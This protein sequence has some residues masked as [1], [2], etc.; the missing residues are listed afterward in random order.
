MSGIENISQNNLIDS[1]VRRRQT[2]FYRIGNKVRKFSRWAMGRVAYN[3]GTAIGIAD[4]IITVTQ[5]LFKVKGVG[6]AARPLHEVTQVLSAIFAPIWFITASWD[7]YEEFSSKRAPAASL[8]ELGQRVFSAASTVFWWGESILSL[9]LM[10]CSF[11]SKATAAIPILGL[12]DSLVSAPAALFEAISQ[13]FEIK[14]LEEKKKLD[15]QRLEH[16]KLWH[17]LAKTSEE[18]RL[19]LLNRLKERYRIKLM[20]I[21]AELEAGGLAVASHPL[22]KKKRRTIE[23]LQQIDKKDVAALIEGKRQ[24]MVETQGK[25]LS[26]AVRALNA[27]SAWEKL[28]S[29]ACENLAKYYQDKLEKLDKKDSVNKKKL[30]SLRK[31]VALCIGRSDPKSLKKLLSVQKKKMRSINKQRK[32]WI[33]EKEIR[34]RSLICLTFPDLDR[35]LDQSIQKHQARAAI[36]AGPSFALI[37]ER[38]ALLLDYRTQE[39]KTQLK[40]RKIEQKRAVLGALANTAICGMAVA[41]IVLGAVALSGVGLPLLLPAS[42][43]LALGTISLTKFLVNTFV[44]REKKAPSLKDMD[45]VQQEGH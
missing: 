30:K 15:S 17:E 27:L 24:R 29:V 40:N 35:N 20:K 37:T 6:R 34:E 9:G 23:R 26:K 32:K 38:F 13:G 19:D 16:R 10:A 39:A 1:A 33:K 21:D 28:D 18:E 31:K 11:I 2:A 4:D 12:V 7:L 5:G 14:A 3:V 42:I 45:L 44:F 41:G 8:E 25:K 36:G 22:T 43:S